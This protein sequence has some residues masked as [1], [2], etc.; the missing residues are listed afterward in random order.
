ML[1]VYVG[2]PIICFLLLCSDTTYLHR[3]N[4]LQFTRYHFYPSISDVVITL[5]WFAR[6]RSVSHSQHGFAAQSA[7]GLPIGIVKYPPERES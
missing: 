5:S 1:I 6:E 4:M 7:E 2:V 3:A